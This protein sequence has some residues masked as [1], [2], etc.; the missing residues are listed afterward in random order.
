MIA[1]ALIGADWA[2][3]PLDEIESPNQGGRTGREIGGAPWPVDHPFPSGVI[4][5]AIVLIVGLV[6]LWITR[7]SRS[8][9]ER[10]DEGIAPPTDT[11]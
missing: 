2:A 6:A 8:R 1:L 3:I 11:R 10:P 5:A 7:Q 4:A 9:G